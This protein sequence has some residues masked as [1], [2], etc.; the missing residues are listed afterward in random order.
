MSNLVGITIT[1]NCNFISEDNN[2][3]LRFFSIMPKEPSEFV[4]IVGNEPLINKI[5]GKINNNKI[6]KQYLMEINKYF[7]GNP[8]CHLFKAI[9]I[10]EILNNHD[11]NINKLNMGK[12]LV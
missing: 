7:K 2:D 9:Q 3:L 11:I 5:I 8:F 10:K 4:K 6:L 12:N 1:N